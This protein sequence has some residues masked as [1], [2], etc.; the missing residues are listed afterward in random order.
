[1][2]GNT[3]AGRERRGRN[4]RCPPSEAVTCTESLS[5]DTDAST[6]DASSDD[7]ARVQPPSVIYNRDTTNTRT[8]AS[9]AVKLGYVTDSTFRR[10]QATNEIFYGCACMGL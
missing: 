5:N 1:M 4:S 3:D 6:D 8:H 7:N 10:R 9:I 2:K